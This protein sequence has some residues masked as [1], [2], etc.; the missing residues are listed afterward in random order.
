MP[1]LTGQYLYYLVK[2]QLRL[3]RTIA[4][5]LLQRGEDVG[6]VASM[7]MGHRASGITCFHL[8]ELLAARAHLEQALARF[9][10]AHRSFYLSFSVSDAWVS[11]LDY[12]SFDLFCL[13]YLDQARV[14]IETAVEEARKLGEMHFTGLNVRLE[15][16][17]VRFPDLCYL[18]PEK[19]GDPREVQ[20]LVDLMVEVVS[21]S[22]ADRKRDL[23]E[24]RADYARTGVSEYWI[25][26]PETETITVLT[27]PAGKTE[28]AVHGEFKPGQQA[29]SVLLPLASP[30]T[31]ATSVR[32]TLTGRRLLVT[33]EPLS[34]SRTFGACTPAGNV[35]LTS[36]SPPLTNSGRGFESTR[37]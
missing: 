12:L 17:H 18:S 35:T 13:G 11:L 1:V 29:T 4:A 25:V 7:V 15:P 30:F 36:T 22:P 6:D 8:G 37:S 32:S 28:Y 21:P 34:V 10:P 14:R 2:G 33:S 3:A 20:D 24:K 5:D 27:L 26:D 19:L 23:E 9:D 31:S 16:D